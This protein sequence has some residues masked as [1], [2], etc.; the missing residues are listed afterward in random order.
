MFHLYELLMFFLRHPRDKYNEEF[1]GPIFLHFYD[2]NYYRRDLIINNRRGEKLKCCFFTPFNYNENTPCVIYTHSSCSCQ[3]EVLDILHIL[4]VCECSIFSY[5][6]SGCGLS[7]G[8]FSTS[9]W[10]ESQDLFLILHHLRN[11]ENI[12]NFALWGKYSGAVSSIIT[13]SLDVNIK[14]LILDSPYVSLAELY[15]TTFHLGEK[16]KGEIIFKNMC[17]YFAR[18]RIKKKFNY[19]IDN[20]CPIFFIENVTIPTVYIIS[21]NDK[22]V[23]P[24]HT[25]YLAYKQHSSRKIIYICEK[26]THSYESFSYENKLTAAIKSVLFGTL[27]DIKNIFNVYTYTKVFNELMEKYAYEFHFIDSLINKKL[28]K[29]NKII[30]EVKKFIY[31]KY[32]SKISLASSS[33][34]LSTID[35]IRGTN[36]TGE[37][38]YMQYE[39]SRNT[40]SGKY[41]GLKEEQNGQ[42]DHH[43]LSEEN[44][45]CDENEMTDEYEYPFHDVNDII[46]SNPDDLTKK[47]PFKSYDMNNVSKFN[48]IYHESEDNHGKFKIFHMQSARSSLKSKKNTYKKSLTWDS[49]L[50]S[51]VTYFKGDYPFKLQKN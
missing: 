12:K 39:L 33:F 21:R 18:R 48:Q 30:D 42:D 41:S 51:S 20:I 19:D 35:S 25:L 17:L 11:V 38:D 45:G 13:A 36:T 23:H 2:K 3:L 44:G 15:K 46:M 4:F 5:D 49:K 16:G 37:S 29:K 6:C 43:A 31:F 40:I 14:L 1:L 7:D 27:G 24:A 34:N 50:Q 26:A 8:Y 22:F 28:C 32:Q 9:G 47:S 10:N